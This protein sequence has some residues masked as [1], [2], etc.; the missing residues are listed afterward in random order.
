MLER[1]G[2]SLGCPSARNV[3]FALLNGVVN[4]GALGGSQND[5]KVPILGPVG[6]VTLNGLADSQLVPLIGVL[7]FAGLICIGRPSL[8]MN[9]S[10]AEFIGICALSLVLNDG[11]NKLHLL[12]SARFVV[13]HAGSRTDCLVKGVSIHAN[14]CI[15]G[16]CN[17]NSFGFLSR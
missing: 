16:E 2:Q 1:E 4:S 3:S 6:K 13:G 15:S 5:S 17:V 14:R 8:N 12:L 10:N 11:N 7:D 9:C